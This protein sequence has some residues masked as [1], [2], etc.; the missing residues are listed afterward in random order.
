MSTT[1][2]VETMPTFEPPGFYKGSPVHRDRR[3]AGPIE[4]PEERCAVDQWR[5]QKCRYG[6]LL[7]CLTSG[8]DDTPQW[9]CNY[10]ESHFSSTDSIPMRN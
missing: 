5:L 2:T 3:I 4:L 10:C 6:Y 1:D 7:F 8:C 9:D